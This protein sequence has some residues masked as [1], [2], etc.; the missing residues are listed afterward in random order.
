MWRHT[1]MRKLHIHYNH[2]ATFNPIRFSTRIHKRKRNAYPIPIIDIHVLQS[3]HVINRQG[4]GSK[5]LEHLNQS[6]QMNIK[7]GVH[8]TI[9]SYQ[10]YQKRHQPKDQLPDKEATR[11]SMSK[12]PNHRLCLDAICGNG[13]LDMETC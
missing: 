8:W 1:T 12:D 6:T 11:Q 7:K 9:Q 2:T 3:Q 4:T 5:H 13:H 10:K